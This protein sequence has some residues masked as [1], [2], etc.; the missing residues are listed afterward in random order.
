MVQGIVFMIIIIIEHYVMGFAYIMNN[1]NC[2]SLL[3][4]IS[5]VGKDFLRV[6]ERAMNDLKINKDFLFT[7]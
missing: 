2:S 1:S 5:I 7:I 4:R 3:A 6:I